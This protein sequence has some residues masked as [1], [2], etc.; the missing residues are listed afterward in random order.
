MKIQ[1]DCLVV[2]DYRIHDSNGELFEEGTGDDA[3]DY[4]HGYG[5]LPQ[6]VEEALEG[7][8]V[9]AKIELELTPETGFGDVD[10]ELIIGVPRAEL[11]DD[12]EVNKGDVL[13]VQV[14]DDD[15]EVQGEVDMVVVEVRADTIFVD[16]NHPLAGQTVKFVAEVMEVRA[17]TQEELDTVHVH[18]EDCNH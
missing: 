13:P 2:L 15:G 16:A 5:E 9:G 12:T 6:G 18:D 7:Q 3:T 11:G 14:T 4:I 10:P 8:T 17:A 1:K